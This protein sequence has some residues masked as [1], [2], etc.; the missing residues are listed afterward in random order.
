MIPEAR[1]VRHSRET[2]RA[3]RVGPIGTAHLE[4]AHH[5]A[6]HASKS[7]ESMGRLLVSEEWDDRICFCLVGVVLDHYAEHDGN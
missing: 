6:R 4:Q 1:V 5:M 7:T 2:S 3:V